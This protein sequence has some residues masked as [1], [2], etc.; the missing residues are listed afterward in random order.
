MC[1]V[2]GTAGT[3]SHTLDKLWWPRQM[4]AECAECAESWRMFNG[5]SSNLFGIKIVSSAG[6][7]VD[8]SELQ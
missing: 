3:C 5:T 1:V 7:A 2:N 8:K 4:T 6:I